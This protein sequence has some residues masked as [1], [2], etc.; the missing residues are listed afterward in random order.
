MK[1]STPKTVLIL[2]IFPF[3]VQAQDSVQLWKK[4][5]SFAVNVNQASFSS[6]WKAGGINSF[7]FN[8]LYN[9]KANYKKNHTSWDNE[10]DL[11]FGLVNNKGQGY[12]KTVDRIFLDTKVGHD[13]NKNWALFTSLNVLTQ[14][15]QG[16]NYKDDGT[17]ELISDALAP[18]FITSAWGAEYHP[19]DYFKMRISPFAPRITIVRD[20]ERFVTLENPKPYG[21]TP[22]DE[23]RFEWLSFQLLAEFNKEIAT[24]LNLKWRYIM[25]ANYQTFAFKSID[26]RV[27][28][29]L[30]AKV[31]KYVNVTL[32]GILIYDNDQDPDVQLSQV[33]SLGFLYT[34]QNYEE[35]KK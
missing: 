26:H 27:D 2:L 32:G 28:L 18:A 9:Y 25:Y 12:R 7:G 4:K 31:N 8:S 3:F 15:A 23:I 34:F 5:V 35:E 21:V 24:N 33:F 22:P 6:N 10:I 13:M 20:P 14:F 17:S 29:D 19:V 16:F 1:L 30:V 11:A